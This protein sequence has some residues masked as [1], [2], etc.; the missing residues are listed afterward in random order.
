MP[1]IQFKIG[2]ANQIIARLQ[3][4]LGIDPNKRGAAK[5]TA[6]LLG[7][8]Q[9]ALVRWRVRDFVG[10]DKIMALC[11]Q[12]N[13]DMNLVFRGQ[14]IETGESQHDLELVTLKN[15]RDPVVE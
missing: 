7:I 12:G 8:S 11:M 2:P 13:V 6:K 5:A 10:V 15:P 9:Q 3:Q 14:P 4:Q 1:D